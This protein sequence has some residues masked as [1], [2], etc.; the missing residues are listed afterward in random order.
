MFVITQGK[1]FHIQFANGWRVSVQWGITNY[2]DIRNL[3]SALKKPF[4]ERDHDY[5]QSKTAECAV[6]NPA[7]SM[8]SID[9]HDSVKGWMKPDDVLAL[10]V[11]VASGKFKGEVVSLAD[12]DVLT[13]E[14]TQS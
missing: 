12:L 9:K 3:E 10:M 5:W 13:G 4:P 1:G 6:F 2:C 11:E 7:G 14:D 8:V